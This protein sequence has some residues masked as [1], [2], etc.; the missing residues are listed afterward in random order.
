VKAGQRLPDGSFEPD[1][2]N[3]RVDQRLREMAESL[4][5][6]GKEGMQKN[7]EPEKPDDAG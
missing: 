4:Q 7:Q 5:K 1:T 6:F 3:A 2:V